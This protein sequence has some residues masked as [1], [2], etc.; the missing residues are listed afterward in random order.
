MSADVVPGS[1]SHVSS[2]ADD[3]ETMYSRR[4]SRGEESTGLPPNRNVDVASGRCCR[5]PPGTMVIYRVDE[6]PPVSGDTS[7]EVSKLI[8]RRSGRIGA[9]WDR[10]VIRQLAYDDQSAI[11]AM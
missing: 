1:E 11:C 9:R 6:T 8:D 5:R 7:D 2:G 3:I 10:P 4:A